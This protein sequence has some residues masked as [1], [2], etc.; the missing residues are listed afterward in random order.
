MDNRGLAG[1]V[2]FQ[3]LGSLIMFALVWIV[4]NEAIAAGNFFGPSPAATSAN[5]KEGRGYIESI[6]TFSPLFAAVAATVALQARAAFE[7]AGGVR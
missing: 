1:W 7:S 6:W 4:L 5:L 3:F 2:L